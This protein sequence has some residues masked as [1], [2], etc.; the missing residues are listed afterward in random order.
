M[1]NCTSD[2][3]VNALKSFGYN[4]VR[5]PKANLQPLELLSQQQGKDLDRLGPM[6]TLLTAGETIELPTVTTSQTTPISGSRTGEL[7]IGVGLSILGNIIGAMGG[8]KLGLD[9]QYKNA[10]SAVFEFQDVQEDKVTIV[11]LDQYLGDADINPASVFLSKLLESDKLYIVTAVLKSKKFAFD[12]KGESG[13]EVKLEVPVIQQ[14]VGGSVN[15]GVAQG[16]TSKLSY[17][18]QT[19]LVFGF[20]AIQVFYESGKYTAFKPASGFTMKAL[21]KVE[22][23]G[24]DYLITEDTFVSL[25]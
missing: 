7:K 21:D 25:A 5:L 22:D 12:A 17:E 6:G 23:S 1:F 3:F 15:V 4:M 10:K 9:V 18:G 11:D 16:S 14:A 13:T 8:S 20:Q 24:A 19:P 2:P